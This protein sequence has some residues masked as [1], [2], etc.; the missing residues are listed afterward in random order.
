MRRNCSAPAPRVEGAP[1]ASNCGRRPGAR[2][3]PHAVASPFGRACRRGCEF[4]G[5]RQGRGDA[6][7]ALQPLL[8]G[9]PRQSGRSRSLDEP[10]VDAPEDLT[11]TV[12]GA[13]GAEAFHVVRKA[14]LGVSA[15]E[16]QVLS[17]CEPPMS[18]SRTRAM[19]SIEGC[20]G[21]PHHCGQPHCLEN[22][23][24]M[25]STAVTGICLSEGTTKPPAWHMAGSTSAKAPN[26]RRWP[27][28]WPAR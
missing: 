16:I 24:P 10:A 1:G 4:A 2:G 15:V 23:P 27:L 7:H 14:C 19:R 21:M 9:P 12:A 26:G 25:W 6:G 13:C 5:H 22:S 3:S 8:R 18:S 20:A 28:M 11:V 17:A